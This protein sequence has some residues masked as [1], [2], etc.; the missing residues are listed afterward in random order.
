MKIALF[1]SGAGTTVDFLLK[2]RNILAPRLTFDLVVTDNPNAAVRQVA[3]SQNVKVAVVQ[4]KQFATYLEWDASLASI[5]IQEK[6]DMII[7]VG[8]LRKIGPALLRTYP[9]RIINTHPSLLPKYGGHG[10]YGQRVHEAV[11]AAGENESGATLHLVNE[12][13]DQGAILRQRHVQIEPSD[14]PVSLAEKVKRIE[15]AQL[16]DFLKSE[17]ELA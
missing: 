14:T 7:L 8:F 4:P 10:M 3:S 2:S 11:I 16:L 1:A 5:L 12:E 17:C 13:Y 15:K 9:N 6:I